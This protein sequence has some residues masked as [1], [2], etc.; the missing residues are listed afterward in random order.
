MATSPKATAQFNRDDVTMYWSG[1]RNITWRMTHGPTGISVEGSTNLHESNFTKKRLR[2]ADRR[3][4]AK[5]LGDLE[6]LVIQRHRAE[7]EAG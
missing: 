2:V 7:R 4:M 5:L 1:G 6:R 3:L